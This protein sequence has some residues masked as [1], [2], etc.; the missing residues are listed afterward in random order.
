MQIYHTFLLFD[1]VF[2]QIN[3]LPYSKRWGAVLDWY[4]KAGLGE[5]G[6]D[7]GGHI[8]GTLGD[9]AIVAALGCDAAE[10]VEQVGLDVGIRVLLHDQGGRGMAAPDC[11][12]AGGDPLLVDPGADGRRDVVKGLALGGD[13]QGVDCLFHGV[14]FDVLQ[15]G[16]QRGEV[17]VEPL[18]VIEGLSGQLDRG[19]GFGGHERS[20]ADTLSQASGSQA[21]SSRVLPCWW[22]PTVE[23]LG[24]LPVHFHAR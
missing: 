3:C 23:Y 17:W 18:M 12:Q 5:G 6:L 15:G 14:F 7:V 4:R 2:K 11:E 24:M 8:V 10:E 1:P 13:L 9:V 20:R 19:N 22:T 16:A 21:V